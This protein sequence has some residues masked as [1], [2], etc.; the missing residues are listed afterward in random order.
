MIPKMV[1]N[2]KE[3]SIAEKKVDRRFCCACCISEIPGCAIAPNASRQQQKI[4]KYHFILK[5]DGPC[6]NDGLLFGKPEQISDRHPT[7][8]DDF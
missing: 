6:I 1:A 3:K 8:A 2:T 5:A 7:G 4:S